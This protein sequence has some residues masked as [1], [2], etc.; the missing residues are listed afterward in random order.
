MTTYT[1]IGEMKL[2]G[3]ELCLDF[4][5][6]VGARV[7]VGEER[8]WRKQPVSILR[9]KING[10]ADLV[11]WGR[12]TGLLT[13]REAQRLRQRA[14]VETEEAASVLRR[15]I[16]LREA[17][18]QIFRATIDGHQPPALSLEMLNEE[19]SIARSH[20]RVAYTS[21]GFTWQWDN[22]G[23]F[24][25]SVLWSVARSA[26]TFLT[27]GDLSRV[28]RCYGDECGWLFVDTSKNRSR[29]WCDMQDCGNLAKV[30]RFRRK[31]RETE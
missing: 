3:G 28:K 12:H 2:V 1:S 13:E 18:Y 24:L 31:Q 27:S 10:Y 23:E 22:R 30:R 19:V 17:V 7:N 20:E 11:T 29:Q 4:I 9:D 6:T 21:A 14:E 15:A 26:T 16:T 25:D 8:N 5:N